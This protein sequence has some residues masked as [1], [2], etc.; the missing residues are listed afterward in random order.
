MDVQSVRV[1]I[2]GVT[3][4]RSDVGGDNNLALTST[5]VIHGSHQTP[6]ASRV[7]VGVTDG[8]RAQCERVDSAT[9]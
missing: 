9:S 7:F 4:N 2:P 1:L 5:M 8:G 6:Q 3:I